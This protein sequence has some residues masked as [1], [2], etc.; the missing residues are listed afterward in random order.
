[1]GNPAF[2]PVGTTL[3]PATSETLPSQSPIRILPSVV[4]VAQLIVDDDGL[5]ACV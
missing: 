4:S 5:D 2:V 1:M 3:A